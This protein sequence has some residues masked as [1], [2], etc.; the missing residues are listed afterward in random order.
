M[1]A[2]LL[3]IGLDPSLGFEKTAKVKLLNILALVFLIILSF[4]AIFHT[5]YTKKY[6]MAL[7]HFSVSFVVPF[8]FFL[9]H[10]HKYALAKV[11]FFVFLHG[12]VFV[13][14]MFLLLGQGVEHFYLVTTILLLTMINKRIWI[15][16]LILL[17]VFLYASPQ[18]FFHPY[19]SNN[20]SFVTSLVVFFA[21]ILSVRY[22]ILVQNQ[23]KER[24]RAQKVHL[25]KLNDE[26]NDLMGIVA[27]DLKSPLAQIKGLISILELENCQ[28]NQ[29]QK[30]V[31]EKIKGVTDNQYKQIT[32]FLNSKYFEDSIEEKVLKKV[33]V[34]D[35][36]KSV[37]DEMLPQSS[38]KNIRLVDTYDVEGLHIAGSREG[39]FK[40]ISNLVSNGIK[41]SYPDT[42]ILIDVKSDRPRPGIQ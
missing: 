36:V 26:K 33:P 38:A 4:F 40:I 7:V 35:T 9:Q 15:Y 19:S 3:L 18:L 21:V 5:F 11:V 23:Y 37:L 34:Q 39:L 6:E 2:K 20:Y 30:L 1:L 14:C 31:I 17:N 13:A 22:F 28:F 10:K 12:I 29:D 8:I 42:E 25:E 41:Y 27:H 32:G 16:I 24:L